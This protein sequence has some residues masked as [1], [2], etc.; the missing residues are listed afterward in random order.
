M[1]V[2]LWVRVMVRPWEMVMVVKWVMGVVT[3]LVTVMQQAVVK[4]M[5]RLRNPVMCVPA[6]AN[7]T[8]A[9]TKTT[10]C[11]VTSAKNGCCQRIAAAK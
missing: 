4:A 10:G 3:L 1:L 8:Y 7:P 2:M 11:L 6:L 5:L 9:R